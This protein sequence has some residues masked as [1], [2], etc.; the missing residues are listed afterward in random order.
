MCICIILYYII[1]Y[2]IIVYYTVCLREADPGE[3]RHEDHEGAGR[4][5]Q[6][7]GDNLHTQYNIL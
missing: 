7:P 4:E 3:L 5:V 2:D 1:L 6:H